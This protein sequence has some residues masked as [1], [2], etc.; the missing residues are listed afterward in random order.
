[1]RFILWLLLIVGLIVAGLMVLDYFGYYINWSKSVL[2]LSVLIP[3]IKA[4]QSF[5]SD[6]VGEFSKIKDKIKRQ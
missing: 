5:F 6:T 4:V 3:V 2:S 1:M